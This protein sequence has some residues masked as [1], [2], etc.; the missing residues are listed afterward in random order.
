MAARS[1]HPA[2]PPAESARLFVSGCGASTFFPQVLPAAG[3]KDRAAAASAGE[4]PGGMPR[5]CLPCRP[6]HLLDRLFGRR[7]GNRDSCVPR[8]GAIVGVQATAF[9]GTTGVVAP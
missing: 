9:A 1:L 5:R 6:R 3:K 7:L 2:L 4:H 8:I